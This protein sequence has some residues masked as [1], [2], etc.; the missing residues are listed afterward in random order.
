[1]LFWGLRVVVPQ[2]LRKDVL[3]LLYESHPGSICYKQIANSYV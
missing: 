1:M 3:E 2:S